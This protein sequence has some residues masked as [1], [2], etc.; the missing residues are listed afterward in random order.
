MISNGK[1]TAA[2]V[3]VSSDK[4]DT[5][6]QE[7]D[8]RASGIPIDLWVHDNE[9]KNPRDLPEKRPGFQKLLAGVRAGIFGTIVVDRQ[10][11][12]GTRDA[13]QW[14]EFI[15]LLR[16]NGCA[17]VDA[18]GKELSADD[19]V[20]ILTGTLGAI[21]ST[22]EQK[23]KGHRSV[24]AKIRDA[25]AGK[26]AGGYPPYGCDAVC[27]GPKGEKW[28]VVYDGHMKRRK[29]FPDGRSERFDG[30]G[31]SPAKDQNDVM[32]DRPTVEAD[33]LGVVKDIF[34]WYATE[35]ISPLQIADRLNTAGIDPVFGTWN[36][37]KIQSFLRNPVYIGRPAWN[38][39]AGSRFSEYRNGRVQAV[40]RTNGR[41]KGGRR[42]APAD[43]VQPDK[44]LFR[45]IV[46]LKTWD[47]VQDK[48][49]ASSAKHTVTPRRAPNTAA[50][51]LK[52]FLV[53][54]KCNRTMRASSAN[55]DLKANYFDANYGDA[56]SNNPTGCRTHRVYHDR[57]ERIVVDYLK[58]AQP[59]VAQLLESV[60]TGNLELAAPLWQSVWD[61]QND[62]GVACTEM[63][64]FVDQ[65]ET[66]R[67][68][69][70]T[71]PELYGL[72][73]ERMRPGLEKQIAQKEAAIEAELDGF[74]GLS[75]RLKKRANAR[76]EARQ[77]EVDALTRQ[78][79]DLRV[80]FGDMQAEL[81]TR[82]AAYRHALKTIK[83]DQAYRQKAEALRAVI[84]KIVLHF[85]YTGR[86]GKP[87]KKKSFLDRVEIIPVSGETYRMVDAPGPG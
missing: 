8:I 25:K 22:R 67:D 23:E 53:C 33:R 49:K 40:Q 26:R 19:D 38:K 31:N 73:Y 4:Q 48:L 15:S 17:L 18:T 59:K 34:R 37:Q 58:T 2:Y 39:R 5:E 16:E 50:L 45:P 30:K 13:Y 10:D 83:Q 27:I 84:D 28:R 46:S 57:I 24:T 87:T 86:D 1:Q 77:D 66:K 68:K 85:R 47:K 42:R 60:E 6:R 32:Q 82:K 69:A 55:K 29:V 72:I 7:A 43:Y 9:G 14:G 79:S 62:Y 12:F 71:F 81:K 63:M 36:K 3:R 54:G 56:G 21:T 20:S 11:R 75:D 65:H 76:M 44:P 74:K 52:P 41:V 35:D 70:E 61:A 64:L 51:W 80:S 78:L